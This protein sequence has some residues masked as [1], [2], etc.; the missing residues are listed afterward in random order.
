M[1]DVGYYTARKRRDR[2][3]N[4]ERAADSDGFCGA[5]VFEDI[6]EHGTRRAAATVGEEE[7]VVLRPS[8]LLVCNDIALVHEA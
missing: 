5:A 7:E 8:T 3:R 6:G 1:V 4:T 2:R